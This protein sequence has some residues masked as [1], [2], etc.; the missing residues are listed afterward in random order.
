[1][2]SRRFSRSLSFPCFLQRDVE[3]PRSG[4]QKDTRIQ[5]DTVGSLQKDTVREAL[6]F[7][8]T[9]RAQGLLLTWKMTPFKN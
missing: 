5:K 6:P 9:T 1:M 8:L 3:A 2:L 7:D 4:E